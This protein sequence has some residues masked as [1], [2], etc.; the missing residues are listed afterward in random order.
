[1][2]FDFRFTPNVP[3]KPTPGVVARDATPPQATDASLFGAGYQPFTPA[4]AKF[5]PGP[6]GR[7]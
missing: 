2:P 6:S 1:M 3:L 5:A 4:Q 7:P